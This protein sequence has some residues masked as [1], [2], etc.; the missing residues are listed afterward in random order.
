MA[1]QSSTTVDTLG[2]DPAALSP[3]ALSAVRTAI[4][5]TGFFALLAGIALV[6]WPV[7]SLVVLGAFTGAY[8]VLSG[9]ARV[10]LGLFGR[11]VSA[12]FRVL[13]IVMGLVLVLA[14]VVALKNLAAATAV[15]VLILALSI[16]IGWIAEGVLAIV[17]AGRGKASK[18]ALLGGLLSIVAGIVVIAVPGWSVL[19]FVIIS[20]AVLIVAGSAAIA[21]AFTLG[22]TKA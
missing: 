16:G 8:F 11:E 5:I 13:S 14:G 3:S 7:K 4:G 1:S 6:A 10:A 17:A 12:G 2:F 15:L 22:K 20:G 19:W 9:I 18:W 21:Q